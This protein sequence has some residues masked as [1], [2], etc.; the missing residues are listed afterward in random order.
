MRTVHCSDRLWGVSASGV[1]AREGVSAQGG[2]VS[3][4]EGVSAQ[5]VPARHPPPPWTESQTGVKTLS[6]RN[7]VAD[8]KKTTLEGEK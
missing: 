4:W 2:G 7:Y 3:A 1:S 8:G 6:C 5:G